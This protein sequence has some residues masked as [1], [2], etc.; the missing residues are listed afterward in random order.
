VRT[1]LPAWLRAGRECV[2]WRAALKT[3][4]LP[5]G[6]THIATSVSR[7]ELD[8]SAP[9]RRESGAQRTSFFGA[10]RS[11]EI[12]QQRTAGLMG[13]VKKWRVGPR[14]CKARQKKQKEHERRQQETPPHPKGNITVLDASENARKR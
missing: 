13:V 12:G 6:R 8:T 4:E 11:N 10:R 2:T 9:A 5:R 1:D 7:G 14:P 3:W